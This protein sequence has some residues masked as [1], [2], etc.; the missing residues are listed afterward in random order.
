VES[1]GAGIGNEVDIVLATPISHFVSLGWLQ[2]KKITFLLWWNRAKDS[3]HH[4]VGDDEN[5]FLLV[6]P[7]LY[8]HS[9]TRMVGGGAPVNRF[10]H[11]E[12]KKEVTPVSRYYEV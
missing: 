4:R 2:S 9:S 1:S 10:I 7:L 8:P 6:L 12:F 11:C 5:P 3:R